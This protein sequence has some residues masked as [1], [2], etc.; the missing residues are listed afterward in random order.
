ME[1][2]MDK[3][4]EKDGFLKLTVRERTMAVARSGRFWLTRS[5]DS[6]DYFL[7]EGEA[8]SLPKGQWLVQAL[9]AG[10]VSCTDDV[11]FPQKIAFGRLS[12]EAGCLPSLSRV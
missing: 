8:V 10:V 2:T 4:L 12:S 1:A 5:G 7:D 9:L 11:P 3:R 6:D